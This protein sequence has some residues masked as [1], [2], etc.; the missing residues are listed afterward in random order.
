[1]AF[2]SF[3]ALFYQPVSVLIAAVIS[4]LN[5]FT[6]RNETTGFQWRCSLCTAWIYPSG[7]S[8][9]ENSR[10][11]LSNPR[12]ASQMWELDSDWFKA[13]V[14][15][16]DSF[17]WIWL[18]ITCTLNISESTSHIWEAPRAFDKLSREFSQTELYWVCIQAMKMLMSMFSVI[19]NVEC[20]NEIYCVHW[21]G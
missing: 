11:S 21:L 16:D 2:S 5:G 1:M 15:N 17:D 13:H 10:D 12:R 9:C 4:L 14:I 6:Q 8:V 19:N 18:W 3:F 7:N 20:F